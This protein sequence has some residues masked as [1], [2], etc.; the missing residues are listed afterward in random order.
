M[1]WLRA[2]LQPAWRGFLPVVCA[3]AGLAVAAGAR[4][5]PE[6]AI[7]LRCAKA[8]CVP[9]DGPQVIDHALVI[10]EDGRI[11][12]V[13]PAA[14]TP[15]PAGARVIDVGD[16]WLMPGMVGL[17]SHV[18]GPSFFAGN[19]LNDGVFL[20]NP[21]L[22]ASSVVLPNNPAL[23]KAVGGGRHNGA[24]YSRLRYEHGRARRAREDRP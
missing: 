12:A 21:G 11:K 14:T 20:T 5:L 2:H 9:Y 6:G 15:V 13:G 22:R 19:D 24:F 4:A 1:A 7:A 3:L 10:I 16:N 17:H 8:L 18:A 23:R